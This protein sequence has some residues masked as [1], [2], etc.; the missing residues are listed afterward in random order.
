M[1]QLMKEC[2]NDLLYEGKKPVTSMNTIRADV[3]RVLSPDSFRDKMKQRVEKML[4]NY[5]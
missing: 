5:K 4:L 3:R 2:N 1:K